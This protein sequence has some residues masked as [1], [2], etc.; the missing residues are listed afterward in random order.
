VICP[1][2]VDTDPFEFNGN[3]PVGQDVFQVPLFSS[4]ISGNLSSGPHEITITNA[5]GPNGNYF[6][7][8]FII[9]EGELPDDSKSKT[10]GNNG[11]EF[12]FLPHSNSTWWGSG[13][14]K[15]SYDGTLYWTQ[16]SSAAFRFNFTG[17]SV[18]L[19]GYL[20]TN[21]GNF[22]CSIDGVSRGL[23]S[24][25]YPTQMFH[26]LVCFG[27]N[28]DDGDHILHVT[29][30]PLSTDD[31]WFSVDYAE[32]RG[33]NLYVFPLSNNSS[34][35]TYVLSAT[36]QLVQGAGKHLLNL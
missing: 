9:W 17:Q 35:L 11:T 24:G 33:T 15:N 27:D 28:L 3:T 14:N 29:N 8:D 32:V 19:Y 10:F 34:I 21:H 22:S 25:Y 36:D 20:D 26:Q 12:E 18:A 23:Y 1:S 6:D 31:G 2:P 16:S 4:G 13:L 5:G 7:I 30:L